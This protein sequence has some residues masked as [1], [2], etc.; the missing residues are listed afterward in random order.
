[1]KT[2]S[3]KKPAAAPL[4]TMKKGDPKETAQEAIHQVMT[5]TNAKVVKAEAAAKQADKPPM[6]AAKGDDDLMSQPQKKS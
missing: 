3:P 5:K 2:N 6:K 1:M 4:K